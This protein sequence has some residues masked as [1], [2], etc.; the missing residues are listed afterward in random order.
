MRAGGIF[1]GNA[2]S[3]AGLGIDPPFPDVYGCNT[4]NQCQSGWCNTA[5][6]A[7]NAAGQCQTRGKVNPG[8]GGEGKSGAYCSD[9]D[10]CAFGLKC[11]MSSKMCESASD[12]G[13]ACYRA[14]QMGF[15]DGQAAL[16]KNIQAAAQAA[17]QAGISATPDTL[18]KLAV[19]YADGY[20]KGSAQ[21]AKDTRP[22]THVG[23]IQ[24]VQ[25]LIGTSPTGRWTAA[26][27]AALQ[28]SGKSFQALAPG[29]IG[30]MPSA[31]IPSKT[32]PK[33]TTPG[34]TT[35]TPPPP[36]DKLSTASMLGNKWALIGL[37]L[38]AVGGVALATSKG[39]KDKKGQSS[40]K[41]NRRR[42][43]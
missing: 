7:G 42:C 3:G 36:E 12:P 17:A 32:P 24:K 30:S 28:R 10:N 16:P 9:D 26:D 19:C 22:C 2:L 34:T 5:I 14:N 37:A 21:A 25:R 23:Q 29:C 15:Q 1:G 8:I 20:V 39:K 11:N 38:L 41:T 33:V 35:G 13:N 31:T 6:P 27:Q 18:M 40:V 43:R 4:D